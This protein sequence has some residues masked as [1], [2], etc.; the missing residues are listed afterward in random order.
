MKIN[1]P[2]NKKNINLT[3]SDN[4]NNEQGFEVWRSTKSNTGFTKLATVSADKTNYLN[5]GLKAST[6]YYYKV[7]AYNSAGNSSYSNVASA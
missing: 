3:W 6:T 2:Q 1:A 5:T 7:R 4:S